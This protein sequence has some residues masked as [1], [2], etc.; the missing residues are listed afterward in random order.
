MWRR[1]VHP[2]YMDEVDIIVE[3]FVKYRDPKIKSEYD[4]FLEVAFDPERYGS[5]EGAEIVCVEPVSRSHAFVHFTYRKYN[6]V[7][8]MEIVNHEG[9]LKLMQEED[10][11]IRKDDL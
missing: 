10:S 1:F 9:L 11:I 6:K 2:R 7:M 3:R 5:P 4:Y 8:K